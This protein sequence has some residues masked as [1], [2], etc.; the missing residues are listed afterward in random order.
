[1]ALL[2]VL[3]TT[4]TALGQSQPPA[5]DAARECPP[6]YYCEPAEAP[7]TQTPTGPVAPTPSNGLEQT[8][9]NETPPAEGESTPRVQAGESEPAESSPGDAAPRELV[10]IPP[11]AAQDGAPTAPPPLPRAWARWEVA[12][13]VGLPVFDSGAQ[14]EAFMAAAGLA[15]RHRFVR[16]AA[17]ELAT[18][19]A[20][21]TDYVGAER[22]ELWIAPAVRL[23]A[24]PFGISPFFAAGPALSFAW[25]DNGAGSR[26]F[27]YLAG[28]VSFGVAVPVSNAVRAEL[29]WSSFFR[30]RVPS[31]GAPE[32][33][34]PETGRTTNASGGALIR[35][36]VAFRF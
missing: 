34:D 2:L 17:I 28:A 3:Q 26:S 1:L 19:G 24:S 14:R 9:P 20:A 27:T 18:D 21:G 25:V 33:V 10:A 12:A 8:E 29:A 7:P 30:A 32:Y 31:S 15:V 35:F 36:G 16:F 4:T 22:K 6:G 13:R 11:A 23:E 5:T